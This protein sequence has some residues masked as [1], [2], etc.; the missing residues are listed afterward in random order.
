MVCSFSQPSILSAAV[1]RMV[2]LPCDE[3]PLRGGE[4]PPGVEDSSVAGFHLT[5]GQRTGQA[6]ATSAT[7]T[8]LA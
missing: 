6:L 4:A 5:T 1:G 8:R 3:N 7:T 2:S